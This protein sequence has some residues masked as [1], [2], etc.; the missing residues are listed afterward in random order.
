[1]SSISRKAFLS[2]SVKDL[3]QEMENGQLIFYKN[4]G[5]WSKKDAKQ[6]IKSIIEQQIPEKMTFK[7][8]AQRLCCYEGIL[9]LQALRLFFNGDLPVDGKTYDDLSDAEKTTINEF[10]IPYLLLR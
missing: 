2:K 9:Q 1:M 10:Q 7:R 4:T 5:I 8:H 6:F 3:V